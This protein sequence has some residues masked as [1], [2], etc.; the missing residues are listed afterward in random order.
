MKVLWLASWYPNKISPL[1]GDF[2]QRHALAV[3]EFASVSVIY[4]AQYGESV[5]NP[6]PEIVETANG[7]V[8]ELRVYFTSLR[9]GIRVLDK[10][11]Y[12]WKY[13]HTYRSIIRSYFSEYGKPDL[14]HVHVPMKAGI[15][16]R[17]IKRRWKI[18]YVVTEHSAIYVPGPADAFDNRSFY[19][20]QNVSAIFR[21]AAGV[22]SVSFH[23]GSIIKKLFGLKMM[24][25][26]HN[27]VDIKSFFY[28]PGVIGARCR[29]IHVSTMGFQKN[30]IGILQVCAK[31][32]MIRE[33]WEL[34][35][36]GPPNA[37][38]V[39]FIENN[40]LK[41]F[42]FVKGEVS[43]KEVARQMQDASALVMFSRYENF[44]CVIIEALCCGL[45]VVATN[46]AGIP[47]AVDASNGILVESENEAQ[48][49]A[50]MIEM[51]ERFHLFDGPGIAQKAAKKYNY[52]TIGKQFFDLYNAVVSSLK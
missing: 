11:I 3:S 42:V 51:I 36:I 31:L 48:L 7:A 6:Q 24:Y 4:V 22:T 50:A 2:V 44:P 15:I 10:L 19:F 26:L 30:T 13:Y 5:P 8:K 25:T 27:V 34:E 39:D 45:P 23:N 14:V 40:E 28:K 47:E 12:N 20:R 49:L 41:N 1:D 43:N 16:A 21:A 38:V 37:P 29:F 35:L 17:W 33:D 52:N 32:K 46:V 9:T 18:P